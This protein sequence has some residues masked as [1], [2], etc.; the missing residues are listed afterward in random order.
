MKEMTVIIH[1]WSDSSESF[2]Q[3]KNYLIKEEFG[4]VKTVLY[5]DYESREDHLKFEDIVD[6]LNDQFMKQGIIDEDGVKKANINVICHSTGGLVIRHWIWRYYSSN[7]QCSGDI[8]N[9]PVKKIVMLAP[10]NFGSH[11]AHRGK[12]FFSSLVKGRWKFGDFLETGKGIL[13]GLELGSPYQWRLAHGDLICEKPYYN[14]N[15]VQVTILVGIEGYGGVAKV[16]NKPGTD[17][18]VIIAGT[19]LDSAKLRL[20][21]SK[22]AP[23][24][25]EQDYAPYQWAV[26]DPQ[27]DFAFGVLEGL[28]HGSV[29]GESADPEKLVC[30]LLTEALSVKTAKEFGAFAQKVEALTKATY[31]KTAK[32]RFQ[33]FLVHAV[34]DQGSSVNDFTLDFF[35]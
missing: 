9:C 26:E 5:A 33:Q 12:S 1:G 20:D 16:V 18:T 2:K 34:D 19:S 25:A 21:F 22:P 23:A 29:V 31:V 3:L 14:R 24:D 30:Q 8:A 32:P 13:E 28:D 17:G 7:E 6:G 15:Q 11:L 27:G 10:A 35:I 4:T